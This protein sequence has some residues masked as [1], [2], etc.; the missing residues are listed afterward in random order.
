M[1]PDVAAEHKSMV[2]R[3]PVG[4]EVI[5]RGVHFRVWAPDRRRVAVVVEDGH[6]PEHELVSE[7]NGY[8]SGVA[9]GIGDGALYRYRL[10]GKDAFPDPAS[11]F[12]PQG[13]KGPS[14]VV[15]PMRFRWTD[16]NWPGLVRDGQVLYEM[17]V[18]TFTQAGTWEAA[19]AELEFLRDLGV[20]CLE[21]MPVA[22]FAGRFGWGYDGVDLF[23]PY[24]HYGPPDAMRAFI[25]AAH[26]QGI[27]VVLDVVLHLGAVEGNFLTEFAKDYF[28][29][30]YE[31]EW[32][33][34]RNFDGPNSGPVREYVVSNLRYWVEEFHVDGFRFD[35][36]QAFFDESA[37]H[38]LR[39]SVRAAREAAGGRSLLLVAENEP[40]K[41]WLL[42]P[43][44]SGGCGMDAAWNDDFHHAAVVCL[45]GL[46]EAYY[47]DYRGTP[48]E[49][50]A[51]AK[52]GYLYQGQWYSWQDKPR[53]FPSLDLPGPVFVNYLQNHDQLANSARGQRIHELT[54][55]GRFRAMTGLMLL[56]P[57]TPLLFQGQEY[58]ASTPFLYFADC[59]AARAKAVFDGRKKFL[60]QFPSYS[61]EE[62]E[63]VLC[64]PCLDDTFARCKLDPRERQ[65]NRWAVELHRDL[66]RLRREDVVISRQRNDRIDGARLGG[67]AFFL[68]YFGGEHGDRLLLVNFG[69]DLDATPLPHPL[70]APPPGCR[71]APLWNSDDPQY[72]GLGVPYPAF[73]DR[74][75]LRAET[76]MLLA[77]V[78]GQR[79]EADNPLPR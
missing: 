63:S 35:A 72:G 57:G 71:W 78:P 61:G 3:L 69:R 18:G 77:S 51:S 26:R 15:D 68:R 73:E 36:T 43:Q 45:T 31:N 4:A 40:Q 67:Q 56:L 47:T 55:P 37:E 54:S 12:Q 10:D 29:D 70:L 34:A 39:E 24:H 32:G 65:Q 64:D 33:S 1:K 74:W 28:T 2:R 9:P 79:P 38:I 41:P 62:I 6:G 16:G 49:F 75:H 17:H 50:I 52:Y 44:E 46:T 11:R 25:D 19:A 58:A 7:G 30:R 22:E 59:E 60:A 5:E 21:I 27:G 66:L 8:F 20:T 53:G 42:R 13:P 48:E 76:T 23:A 14:Q